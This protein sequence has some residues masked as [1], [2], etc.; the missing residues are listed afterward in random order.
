MLPAIKLVRRCEDNGYA[1]KL[2]GALKT[3]SG[4][5]PP[6]PTAGFSSSGSVGGKVINTFAL[7]SKTMAKLRMSGDYDTLASIRWRSKL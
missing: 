1:A 6:F 7:Y 2:L 5:N 3:P 4:D